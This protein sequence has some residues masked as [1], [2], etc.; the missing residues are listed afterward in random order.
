M[1]L[2]TQERARAVRVLMLDVDGVLTD[3]RIIVDGHGHEIKAFNVHDGL[4]IKL[5]REAGIEVAV[6]SA[7]NSPALR[8]RLSELAINCFELGA[9]DKSAG[10]SRLCQRLGVDDTA[11]A[12]VGD[13]WPDLPVLRRVGLAIAVENAHPELFRV[14][15]MVTTR[16]GGDGAIR[17]VADLLLRATG[18]YTAVL[19]RY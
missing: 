7:R 1:S 17:E 2:G 8:R 12:Y 13:D 15:H 6:L 16:R 5:L 14:A 11:V 9:D 4:G 3:G 18:Q 10:Y 19:A